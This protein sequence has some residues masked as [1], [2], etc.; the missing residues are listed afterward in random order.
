[1]DNAPESSLSSPAA[2]G[3]THTLDLAGRDL[4]LPIV[5]IS[6]ALAISLFMIID[7]PISLLS[8]IAAALAS[9]LRPQSPDIIVAPA[10]LGIPLA[11][12]VSR[13]LGL[14]RYV[15]LQKS[16]KIHLSDALAVEI[17][18]ITS[19]GSQRLLLD[20]AAVPLLRGRRVCVVDDVVASGGSMKGALELVRK[21]GGDVVGVGVVLTEGWEWKGV[22]RGEDA[23]LVQGLGH[24]PQFERGK[25]G[26]WTMIG[27]T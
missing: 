10:T 3:Q 23:A 14:E 15:I 18:S 21:A 2:P 7:H 27:G 9:L 16:P 4:T 22:L 12:E 11:V 19:K 20:R 13:A 17:S 25:D 8:H 5:P 26:Q 1:M 24:I 6:P